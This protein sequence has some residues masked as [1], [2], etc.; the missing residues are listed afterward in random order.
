MSRKN[1]MRLL[2]VTGTL[3]AQVGRRAWSAE[4]QICDSC[5]MMTRC[6]AVDPPPLQFN[7]SPVVGKA[8]QPV[9]S[10]TYALRR[11]EETVA[12]PKC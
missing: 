5:T 11:V 3:Q 9:Y 4:T 8:M 1:C 6:R 12:V 2:V 7:D 10:E